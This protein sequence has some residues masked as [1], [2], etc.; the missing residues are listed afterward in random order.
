LDTKLADD[1]AVSIH[2]ISADDECFKVDVQ[3]WVGISFSHPL[4]SVFMA[5][6]PYAPIRV[7]D[8]AITTDQSPGTIC[9]WSDDPWESSR[10]NEDYSITNFCFL[11]ANR[12]RAVGGDEEATVLHV[13]LELLC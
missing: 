5:I 6:G 9:A 7:G 3:I 13:F 10:V 2:I 11:R 1:I 4:H 12:N 8:L